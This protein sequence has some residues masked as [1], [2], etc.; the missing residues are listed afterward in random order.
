[1]SLPSPD[2]HRPDLHAPSQGAVTRKELVL[3]EPPRSGPPPRCGQ[4]EGAKLTWEGAPSSSPR[5]CPVDRLGVA[6][7]AIM[8]ASD[9]DRSRRGGND[10]HT[11]DADPASRVRSS[12]LVDAV[13]VAGTVLVAVSFGW[14]WSR[15]RPIEAFFAGWMLHNGLPGVLLVWLGRLILLRRP[16]HGGGRILMIA[17]AV[18]AVHVLLAA[19]VDAAG[20]AVGLDPVVGA[21]FRPTDHA[22]GLTVPLWVMTWLWLGVAVPLVVWLP[23]TFPDGSLPGRGWRWMIATVVSGTA[24][25]VAAHAIMAWPGRDTPLTANTTP[26]DEGGSVAVLAAV[27]GGLIVVTVVGALAALVVRWRRTPVASRGPF[28]AVGM[29]AATAAVLGTVTWPWQHVWIPTVF[30]LLLG[31]LVTY[32]VAVARF[33]LHDLEPM[34]GRAAVASLL[35][36]AIT[37]LYLGIVVGVGAAIGARGESPL[38]PLIAVAVVAVLFEPARRRSRDLVDRLLYGDVTD[39]HRALERFSAGQTDADEDALS[40]VADVL[41][42]ATGADR[43]EVWV[44]RDATP[45][46][47]ATSGR[48]GVGT[49]VLERSVVHL[50]EP[51]GEIR[52]L[53]TSAAD[54]ARHAD[55]AVDDVIRLLGLLLRNQRLTADLTSQ[56]AELHR[57]RRRLVTVHDDARRGLERDIHDGAQSQ[58][59]AIKLRVELARSLAMTADPRVGEE[60]EAIA[61]SVD[62]AVRSLRQLAR[63][64]HPP[65]LEAHGVAEALRSRGRDLPVA[66]TVH[67]DGFGRSDRAVE[68]AVYFSCLESIHNAVRHGAASHVVV[69]I[70]S[71][72]LRVWFIVT[73]DGCGFD[74]DDVGTGQGLTNVHDRIAALGGGVE[75]RSGPGHGTRLQGE[76][77]RAVLQPQDRRVRATT[78]RPARP[79][80]V[81]GGPIEV[82]HTG[83]GGPVDQVPPSA[84]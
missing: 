57:S 4:P 44:T 60:L 34:L 33:R 42:R 39:R 53:A 83:E 81:D 70:G 80:V 48:D 45:R 71:D 46:L 10:A 82:E 16:G 68:G 14:M 43:V 64:L 35:V 32:V 37:L 52:L 25:L 62:E 36:A 12:R 51:L 59:I 7:W 9:P 28:R 75:V 61:A 15:G 24:L 72:D 65:I 73:D 40:E 29:A 11:I 54:L 17:G 41:R 77:P 56:V 27:G 6:R 55:R 5:S 84:R 78:D 58:L 18:A 1:M 30:A 13:A 3:T 66:L 50:G 63:G 74:P 49:S 2:L 79:E 8:G 69:H 76:L 38:L 21:S 22:L 23:A 19:T 47:A 67:D 31:L 26:L 20:V